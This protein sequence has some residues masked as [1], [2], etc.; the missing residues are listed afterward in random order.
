MGDNLN[1]DDNEKKELLK[2]KES[3]YTG[4]FILLVILTSIIII[5][6]LSLLYLS[7]Q[8]S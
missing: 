6:F 4:V 2:G 7:F 3:I 1:D 5:G 8:N